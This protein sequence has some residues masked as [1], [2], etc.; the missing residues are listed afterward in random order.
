MLNIKYEQKRSTDVCSNF[1]KKL[2]N[3]NTYKFRNIGK[4]KDI[5][6]TKLSFPFGYGL[7]ADPK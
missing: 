4:Q 7:S 2:V 6:I 5:G 1:A 3:R